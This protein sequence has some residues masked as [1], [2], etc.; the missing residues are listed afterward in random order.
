MAIAQLTKALALGALATAA[1]A[2][3]LQP[4]VMKGS[5]L[6]YNNGTQF[7]IKGVAYQQNS[8]AA[9][10]TSNNTQYADPL[11]DEAACTRDV[12]F[13]Q[14]LGTNVIRTYAIDP[15]QNHDKCMS[16]LQ[17]AGIYVISDL[18]EPS[19]SIQRDSPEWNLELYTRYTNVV[20]AL[21][22]YDN[23]I[24]FFAGNEVTNQKNNTGASAYVKAA[25]RDIKAYIKT[26][27]SR[28]LGVGYAANDDSDIRSNLF[29]YMNCGDADSSI[30]YLGFNIYEW[31]GDNT[32]Q[33]S[34]YADRTDFFKNYSVPVFFAEYGCNTQGGAEGRLWQD[35]TAL[36]SSDMTGVWSGG[37]AFMYFEEANDFGLVKIQNNAVS[38]M[39]NYGVLSSRVAAATPTGVAMGSYN[40]SNSPQPCPAIQA[41]WV[42]REQL[43]PTP[44]A[45]V[46]ECMFNSL[47]CVPDPKLTSDKYQKLF[48]SVCGY[49]GSSC[50]TIN[51][52]ASSGN[53]GAFSMCNPSQK[54]GYVLDA[55]YKSQK[56]DASACNFN[57]QAVTTKA[58]AASSCSA[59]LSSA[60]ASASHSSSNSFAVP[61]P[62]HGMLTLGDFTMGAYVLTAMGLGAAM[63]LF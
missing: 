48:D 22:K 9:G 40:P 32:F 34:G 20:D 46:C 11:A 50:D 26:K 28:W 42:A 36:Y 31:C 62:M 4:I 58:S 56:S 18:S 35:T 12:P 8:E 13:L 24:G 54:L 41:D 6:F 29:S 61:L 2:A 10:K 39:K 21:I 15:T 16:L 44:N 49:P 57:G 53:Y 43:P 27:S 55:Y 1:S 33:G 45:T 30:D 23:V 19:L 25:A 7:F 52:N 51:S 47:S 59:A 60:S 37:I 38:T 3:S 5:K 63:V 14:K 17:D